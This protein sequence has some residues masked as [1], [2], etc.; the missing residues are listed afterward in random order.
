M[1]QKAIPNVSKQ[2]LV[3]QLRELEDDNILQRIVFAEIPSRVEYEL[4]E[5]G[6]SLLPVIEVMEKWGS[7]QM[8][9]SC[10]S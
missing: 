8:E 7:S 4:T 5:L 6:L 1:L 2:M 3:N 9:L 10:E